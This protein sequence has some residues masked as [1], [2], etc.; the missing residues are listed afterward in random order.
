MDMAGQVFSVTNGKDT[1]KGNNGTLSLEN[2]SGQKV[3]LGT[4]STTINGSS[5]EVM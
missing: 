5:L 3:E 2:G 4:S 1:V